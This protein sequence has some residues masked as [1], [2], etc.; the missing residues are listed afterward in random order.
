MAKGGG[1]PEET[2]ADRALAEVSA[3]KVKDFRQR[4]APQ[5]AKLRTQIDAMGADGSLERRTA[6]G[7]ATT[8]TDVAF[9]N[10]NHKALQANASSGNL[11]SAGQK[12]GLTTMGDD[13]ATS[14]GLSANQADLGVDQAHKAGLMQ[15]VAQGQGKEA[16]AIQGLEAQAQM[17]RAV[18]NQDAA[19]SLE[20]D[21]GTAAMAGKVAGMAAGS[22]GSPNGLEQPAGTYYERG[23]DN[24]PIP[25]RF[26]R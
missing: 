16:R 12:L 15:V 9:A 23:S 8:D 26:G 22:F 7:A 11:G 3:A 21:M 5:Q 1:G 24:S 25:V 13:Q 2:A 19:Q 4:W 14:V 20:R 6:R 17:A 18:A 10:V